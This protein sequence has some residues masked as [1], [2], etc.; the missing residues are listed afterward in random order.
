MRTRSII[1]AIIGMSFASYRMV[2]DASAAGAPA[3]DP[4]ATVADQSFV[5][6]AAAAST[7]DAAATQAEVGASTTAGES[8]EAEAAA[9]NAANAPESDTSSSAAPASLSG[10]TA[11]TGAQQGDAGNGA[12]VDP[13]ATATSE[14][15]AALSGD[16]GTAAADPT[17]T[18]SIDVE[19]HAEARER[20]AGLMARLH[21]AE[22]DFVHALRNE[23]NEIGTLL[24]LHSVASGKADATGDYSSSDLS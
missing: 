11:A 18:V 9:S 23:L 17:P 12:N 10:D 20:F 14:S 19:D 24:H 22:E 6:G 13:A 16:A 2:D 7:G 4:D 21:D 15:N 8:G 1:A 5:P 3:L